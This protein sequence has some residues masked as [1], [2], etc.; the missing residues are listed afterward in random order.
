MFAFEYWEGT[1][2]YWFI[3]LETRKIIKTLDVVFFEDITHLKDCANMRVDEA[4]AVKV[5]ISNKLDVDELEVNNNNHIEADEE[6]NIEE[7]NDGQCF[8]HEIHM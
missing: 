3:C 5:D 6:P 1:K 4:P 2:A 8:G 7:K